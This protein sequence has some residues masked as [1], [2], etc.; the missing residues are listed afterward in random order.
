MI[1][2]KRCR[3]CGYT[4]SSAKFSAYQKSRDGL[5]S[6]CRDCVAR[7]GRERY[8]NNRKRAKI[9]G[10]KRRAKNKEKNNSD[11]TRWR[12]ELR[13]KAL[14]AYGGMCACCELSRI[15]FLCIDHIEGNSRQHR[16]STGSISIYSRLK[17]ITTQAVSGYYAITVILLWLIMDT[18]RTNTLK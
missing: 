16:R 17:K 12:L 10:R 14:S 9:N 18:V 11:I 5:R 13:N 2:E 15:E 1:S 6:Y 4:M 7:P 8:A 3:K